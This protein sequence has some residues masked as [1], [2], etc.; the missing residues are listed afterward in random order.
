MFSLSK[1]QSM[2]LFVVL[3]S[4]VALAAVIWAVTGISAADIS[5]GVIA[6]SLLT[7]FCSCY[8]RIQLPRLN[9]H[10]TISDG[11]IILTFLLYGG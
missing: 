5:P 4:P 10:L 8:L 1:E 2:N 11:L 7:I 9:I 6:I 3:A